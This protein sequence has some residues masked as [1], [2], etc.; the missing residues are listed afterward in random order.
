MGTRVYQKAYG[1]DYV[2]E[3]P[4]FYKSKASAQ[5]AHE[6]IRPTYPTEDQK[7]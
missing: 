2:P 3:K 6:A 4:P 1:K 7:M 5:E